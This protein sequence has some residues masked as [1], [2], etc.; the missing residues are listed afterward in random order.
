[1][2]NSEDSVCS[3]LDLTQLTNTVD[4]RRYIIFSLL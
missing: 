4:K 1:M 2:T 3:W